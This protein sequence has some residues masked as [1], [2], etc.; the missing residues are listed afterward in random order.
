MKRKGVLVGNSEKNP[1][2]VPR[3]CLVGVARI[4]FTPKRYQIMG[5]N[6]TKLINS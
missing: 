5:F 2:E 3:S 1:L 6:Q 4:F